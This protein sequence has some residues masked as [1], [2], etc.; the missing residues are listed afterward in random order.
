M[1]RDHNRGDGHDPERDARRHDLRE[2]PTAAANASST[3]AR[4]PPNNGDPHELRGVRGSACL[5][6]HLQ[7]RELHLLADQKAQLIHRLPDQVADRPLHQVYHG[8]G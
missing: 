6:L 8:T 4:Y 1:P 5:F 3:T 7:L 2:H